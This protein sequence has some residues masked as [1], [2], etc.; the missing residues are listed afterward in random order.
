MG[1][2][3]FEIDVKCMKAFDDCPLTI[4]DVTAG[5]SLGWSEDDFLYEAARK[6]CSEVEE[7]FT[8]AIVQWMNKKKLNITREEAE[9]KNAFYKKAL[10]FLKTRSSIE[11]R[12]AVDW[13]AFPNDDPSIVRYMGFAPR[14]NV[15]KWANNYQSKKAV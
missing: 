2:T 11:N 13:L 9:K 14:G 5:N 10:D 4:D 6:I 8:R 3:A 12:K 7:E 1:L 15:R